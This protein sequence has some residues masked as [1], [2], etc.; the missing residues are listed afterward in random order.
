M[1]NAQ[2]VHFVRE[3]IAEF[4]EEIL[5]EQLFLKGA[6]DAGLDLVAPNSQ[7]VLAASLIAPAKASEAVIARHDES[8]AADATLR[9]SRE[10]ILRPP[11]ADRIAGG[12]DGVSAECL[13]LL[14]I[15]PQ[16]VGHDAQLGD[17]PSANAHRVT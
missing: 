10:Q 11:R 6:E 4:V 3:F 8:G 5:A 14:C 2:P 15:R 13:A 1:F 12:S 9:E 16:L 17:C 7:V